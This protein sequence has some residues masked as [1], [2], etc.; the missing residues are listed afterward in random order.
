MTAPQPFDS[1]ATPVAKAAADA[2]CPEGNDVVTGWRLSCRITG[3]ASSIGRS[4]RTAPLPTVLI[5]AEAT[6]SEAIPRNAA[7]RARALPPNAAMPA[8]A[9]AHSSP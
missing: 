8:A 6:A 7:R 4:L 3:T 2:A 1:R 9:P 5:A